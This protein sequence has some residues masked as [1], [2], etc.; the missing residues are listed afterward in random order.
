MKKKYS[1]EDIYHLYVQDLYYYLLSL[2]RQKEAAEDLVQEAFY[3]TLIH[4]DSYRGEEVRP[5]LFRIAYNAFI[6]WYR[7]EKRIISQEITDW[8]LPPSPS[9]EEQVVIRSEISEWKTGL[10]ALPAAMQNI[11][12]LRD[13]YG[14][15]YQEI[16]HVTGFTIG[17]VKMDLFRGRNEMRKA[18]EM[19]DVLS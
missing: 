18:R 3:R 10:A 4:L 2:T 6:D 19:N 15:S 16:A 9:T 1:F 14:F 13:Y 11:L 8:H 7:K 17:K 12:L 5:W